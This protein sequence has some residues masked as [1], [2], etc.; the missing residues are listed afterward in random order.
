[1]KRFR[2][3]DRGGIALEF[4]VLLPFIL[5]GSAG[6]IDVGMEMFLQAELDRGV[7]AAA[8]VGMTGTSSISAIKS[9]I[10]SQIQNFLPTSVAGT[11]ETNNTPLTVKTTVYSDFTSAGSNTNGVSGSTGSYG[12]V[13]VYTAT[14]NIPTYTGVLGLIGIKNYTLTSSAIV[15]NEPEH[16]S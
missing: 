15:Q 8:R 14:L 6:L 12:Q 16:V 4:A 1:M 7:A 10:E 3:A 2:R 13:V 5:V 11:L 9:T